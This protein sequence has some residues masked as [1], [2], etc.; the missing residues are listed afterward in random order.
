MLQLSDVMEM[1]KRTK[2]GE[3]NYLKM[4]GCYV[5][6]EKNIVTTMNERFL[7]LPETEFYKYLGMAGA[8]YTKKI[9]DQMLSV[10]MTESERDFGE[11][12]KLLIRCIESELKDD[13]SAEEIFNSIINT[14]SYPANYL[15]LLFMDA[16]DVP[17][18]GTDRADQDESE[19]VFRY[20][21]G[22]ICP[23]GLA[24][25]GLQYNPKTNRIASRE[26]DWIVGEPAVAFQYPSWEERTAEEDRYTFYC[27]KPD[28]IPH[29]FLETCFGTESIKSA[30]EIRNEFEALFFDVTKSKERQEEYV[31]RMNKL[32]NLM[33][34]EHTPTKEEPEAV[35]YGDDIKQMLSKAEIP[36][37]YAKEIER[38]YRKIFPEYPKARWLL[39]SK[40]LKKS[41][42]K[43]KKKE[44]N[45][46]LQKAAAVIERQEGEETDLTAKMRHLAEKNR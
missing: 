6:N 34:I 23:V 33:N 45:D 10:E 27:K 26:R 4:R 41:E 9:D 24:E 36:D 1:K 40:A 5:D 14:Y 22:M 17:R 43:D 21:L 7:N 19:E 32:I 46:L 38:G 2:P 12:K 35:V 15:I 11:M 13:V 31:V 18:A 8:V 25:A 30:T 39:S 37:V 28:D 20:I 29:G 44:I 42:E 16:Y 3:C